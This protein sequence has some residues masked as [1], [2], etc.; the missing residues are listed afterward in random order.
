MARHAAGV[1]DHYV[2]RRDDAL[3]GRGPDEVP[4][5]LRDG[6]VEHGVAGDAIDV[7]PD[8]QDAVGAA[9][10]MAA[11]DDLLVIFGD[12][13]ARTWNQITGFASDT[14][15]P[16]ADAA[17]ST[18]VQLPEVPDFAFDD[19]QPLVRDERGVRIAR[20]LED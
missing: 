17:P 16:R 2:C 7:I 13:I 11:P 12:T 19:G 1:F 5:I 4:R 20:Q 10:G 6:L 14:E 8:E 18:P 3:R 15:T 9:L